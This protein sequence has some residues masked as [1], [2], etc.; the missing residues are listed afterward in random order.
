LESRKQFG[1]SDWKKIDFTK[2]SKH[3]NS[4]LEKYDFGLEAVLDQMETFQ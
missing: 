2:F 4:T 1:A 3:L